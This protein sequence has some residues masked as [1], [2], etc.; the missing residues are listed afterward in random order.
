MAVTTCS[1]IKHFNVIEHIGPGHIPGFV[2]PLTNAFL[3]Q[4]AEKRLGH[5][6]VPTVSPTAHAGLELA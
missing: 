6:I 1:V 3:L 5:G 2:D 4:A